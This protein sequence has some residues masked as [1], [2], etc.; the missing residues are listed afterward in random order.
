[1]AVANKKALSNIRLFEGIQPTVLEVLASLF[2]LEI[3][4]P[5]TVIIHETK[6]VDCM[7]LIKKGVV[8]RSAGLIYI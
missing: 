5:G 8:K 6:P 7:Y 2:E 3:F 4:I 1:M